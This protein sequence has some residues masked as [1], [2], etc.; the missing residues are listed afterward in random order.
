MA[1]KVGGFGKPEDDWVVCALGVSGAEPGGFLRVDHGIAD[2]IQEDGVADVVG[3][4]EGG[5]EAAVVE[6]LGRA[7]VDFFVAA[8]GIVQ[9]GAV[10]GETRRV[11][12]DEVVAVAAGYGGFEPIENVCF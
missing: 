12:D 9:A 5:E 11:E 7:Q 2:D 6:K 10:A 1:Y 4:A 8:E 3:T